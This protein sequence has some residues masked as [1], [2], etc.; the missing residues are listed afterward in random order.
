MS[1]E[2]EK[3]PPVT[4]LTNSRQQKDERTQRLLTFHNAVSE[5]VP[6]CFIRR[7]LQ[8]KIQNCFITITRKNK[9]H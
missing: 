8:L 4:A 2:H 9:N 6:Y 3:V 5:S 7:K 1:T